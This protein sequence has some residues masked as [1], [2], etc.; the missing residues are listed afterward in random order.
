MQ[1]GRLTI[2]RNI[3]RKHVLQA[4][5]EIDEKGVPEGKASRTWF[6]L[7]EGKRYPPKYV[8]SLANK[9]ANRYELPSS[10]FITTE[11]VSYLRRLGFEVVKGAEE[12]EEEE[13]EF[14]ISLERDLENYLA[15][16]LEML[17]KGLKLVDRQVEV[18]TGRVDLLAE[19]S[20]GNL[21]VIELKAGKAS[22]SSLTQLLAYISAIRERERSR[23]VRGIL[24]AHVFP[25]KVIYATRLM[26]YVKLKRYRVRF[27]FE[28][29]KA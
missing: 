22:D 11:A 5:K 10:E 12:V 24:V 17:E 9:Y 18:T 4:L 20:E 28:D 16:N 13:E 19:D 21:V 23:N 1:G 26:P 8:I 14:F 25:E 29:V 3:T 2:P 6:L 27:E 7:Y 15:S